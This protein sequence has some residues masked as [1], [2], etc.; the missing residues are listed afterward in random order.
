MT[1]SFVVVAALSTLAAGAFFYR[2]IGRHLTGQAVEELESKSRL[3]QDF[4]GAET[5]LPA[6][7]DREADRMGQDLSVR[8]TIIA[9]GG[10]VL[11]DTDLDDDALETIE[12]H[13]GR[14]EI[15]GALRTGRGQAIRYSSTLGEDLLYVARR[16]DPGNPERGVVRL[17]IPLTAVRKAR[18]D[19][20]FPL[21]VSALLSVLAAALLGWAR[22]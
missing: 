4:L 21:L 12:N 7:A 6:I 9:A 17:A 1:V 20:R 15:A 19:L 8:V 14:P 10:K 18:E 22:P 13:A 2:A 3:V 5:D 11:G 16:I